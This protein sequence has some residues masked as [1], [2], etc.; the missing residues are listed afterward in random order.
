MWQVRKSTLGVMAGIPGDF[1]PVAFI[2]DSC[3]PVEHLADYVGRIQDM[4]RQFDRQ[5]SLYAH[6]SVGVIHLRPVLNLKQPEDLEILTGIS[7][8]AYELVKKY[9]GSWSG[10]HGDG[11]VRSY[12]LR[13]F[14]GDEIYEA[15]HEVKRILDPLG[16]M[17][18]GKIVDA[19]RP[20][21]NLRIHPGYQVHHPPT[22]YRF[23]REMG[24]A[25]A[26]EMC[27]GVGQC[28]KTISGTM[29]PSYIATRDEEHSTR[30]R[31]NALR[32]A[33]SGRL[34]PDGFTS[35]RLY[36]VLDL[37]LECKACKSECPSNVDMA[38]MKAEFLGH[39]YERHGLPL[40]KRLVAGSRRSAELAS[41]WPAF[42]N[43]VTGAGITRF[44]LEYFAGFDA[45]RRLPKYA[46]R[47]LMQWYGRNP[48][49]PVPG[50]RPAVT[51]FADTFSNFYEPSVGRSAF[52]LLDALGFE[53]RLA[54]PGCCGRPL[55]SA[56]LLGR[57]KRNGAALIRKLESIPG[58]ILVLEPSCYSTFKD[59]YPDLMDDA[60]R[61]T[62]VVE[63]IFSLEEFLGLPENAAKLDTVFE[64]NGRRLLFHGHC[65]QKALI[66]SEP[67]LNLLRHLPGVEIEEVPAGCCGMAGSFGY[68]KQHYEL[69]EKIGSRHLLPAVRKAAA[70]TRIVVSG[71]SCRSQIE[72]F[73]GRKAVHPAE[74][75]AEAL[76]RR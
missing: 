34:G 7:E 35:E 76:C 67:T 50:D 43:L 42:A 62:E 15:F 49:S 38:K 48:Q 46:A 66:G 58:P 5:L 28:R 3:V 70:D 30:G 45:R 26:V 19:Q 17:N 33:I 61:T 31:A 53:V 41:R 74:V 54:S 37:C 55:I 22:F 18:P 65:Q 6:A 44:L 11:L 40:Q 36:R 21:E 27:T 56:G 1:K 16:I 75:L 14:F 29:C 57:A 23:E 25:R 72:H 20:T 73:T 52:E 59:D 8:R 13:E 51:I 47:T 32:T 63:R 10:E 60:R 39:Y 24:F 71:F 69:S 4:C 12:K 2:E 68:E 9:G 64:K